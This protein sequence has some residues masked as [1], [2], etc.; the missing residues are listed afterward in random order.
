MFNQIYS[1]IS[2]YI[3]ST[4][5]NILQKANE[6]EL[7]IAYIYHGGSIYNTP[8]WEYVKESFRIKLNRLFI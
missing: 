1:S 4:N 3:G 5:D 2:E 8:F 7:A 6:V